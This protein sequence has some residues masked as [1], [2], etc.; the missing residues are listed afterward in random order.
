[1]IGSVVIQ[2]GIPFAIFVYVVYSFLCI[3]STLGIVPVLVYTSTLMAIMRFLN[4]NKFN[5]LW[6]C[7]SVA[8]VLS[9]IYYMRIQPALEAAGYDGYLFLT[10]S[11]RESELV[12]ESLVYHAAHARAFYFIYL[13][14]DICNNFERSSTN[15][16][17][18]HLIAMY[19][20]G[21]SY[22][23]LCYTITLSPWTML[24]LSTSLFHF[25]K[26]TMVFWKRIHV[27]TD[28]ILA[29]VATVLF[30]YYRFYMYPVICV[31]ILTQWKNAGCDCGFSLIIEW[32]NLLAI[33]L[34]SAVYGC[35][36]LRLY[37]RALVPQI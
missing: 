26:C 31:R 17:I 24:E 36:I 25:R 12:K 30:F 33:L 14:G 23:N 4:Y 8:L 32:L 15:D 3:A 37:M 9:L 21:G 7:G 10:L 29:L 6:G 13:I 5:H 22:S 35:N 20:M 28:I 11:L 16:K 19:A 34:V 1:M 18:H 27:R 2:N